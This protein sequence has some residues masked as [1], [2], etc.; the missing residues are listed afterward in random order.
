MILDRLW[1]DFYEPYAD[2]AY[3]IDGKPLIAAAERFS[4]GL[5]ED[6]DGRYEQ[7][8]IVWHHELVH[9]PLETDG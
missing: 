9:Q 8:N 6:A 3:K 1:E 7:R 5:Y 2:L 4:W